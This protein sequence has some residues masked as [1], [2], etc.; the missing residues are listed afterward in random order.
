[1]MSYAGIAVAMIGLVMIIVD[2]SIA[3]WDAK[4]SVE[5]TKVTVSRAV[6]DIEKTEETLKNGYTTT[7]NRQFTIE[8]KLADAELRLAT[9]Q[10]EAEAKIAAFTKE[11]AKLRNTIAPRQINP[12]IAAPA[13]KHDS[14][15][16]RMDLE[17]LRKRFDAVAGKSVRKRKP[18]AK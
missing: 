16:V 2:Q 9:V 4:E 1:M 7:I 3:H 15:K 6:A 17:A 18:R 10:R 12:K 11:Q 8:Q 13:P 5:A 14:E